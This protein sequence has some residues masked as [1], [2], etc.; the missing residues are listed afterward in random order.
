MSEWNCRK[1]EWQKDSESLRNLFNTT[2]KNHPITKD[3]YFRWHLLG[4][5]QGPAVSFCAIPQGRND[6]LAG[7]YLVIPSNILVGDLKLKFSTSIYSITHPMYYRKGI[8]KE[9]AERTY[10]EC[11][12][13]GVCGTIGVPNNNSLPGFTKGLGFTAIGQLALMVNISLPFGA[14]KQ[15]IKVEK[16]FSEKELEDK[17]FTLD[18]RKSKSGVVLCERGMDFIRWRFLQ[19]PLAQYHVF[20]V[21][22]PSNSVDG[23]MVIR[24]AKKHGFPITVIVDFLVDHTLDNYDIIAQALLA[25]AYRF[26]WKSYRPIIFTLVNPFSYEAQILTKNG[27]GE[28]SK[29]ILSHE[30]NFILKFHGDQ[31]KDLISLLKNYNNW[32]F[33]FADYDIF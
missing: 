32:Y 1:V 18:Y 6:I 13:M 7:V 2:W 28:V 8:F 20:I 24:N 33:S 22:G 30:N 14:H 5:P 10:N 23:L 4:N 31:P 12:E 21:T 25:E 19:C 29:R 17:K 27:F 16:I 9:L 15:D 3:T 26:A 11:A